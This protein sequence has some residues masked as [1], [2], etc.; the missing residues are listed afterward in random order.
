MIEVYTDGAAMGDPGPSACGV[1]MKHADKHW[2]YSFQLGE[3]SNHEAEF[4]GVI[5]ALEICQSEFPGEIISLRSDSRIV[6]DT[7]EKEFSKNEKFI[8]LLERIQHL[9]NAFA[10]VFIKWIPEKQNKNADRIARS[11]LRAER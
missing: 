10:F 11:A 1:Y 6:V 4:W 3:L 7:L 2:E 8:P 5:K 9:K